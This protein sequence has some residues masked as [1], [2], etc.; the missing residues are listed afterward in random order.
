MCSSDLGVVRTESIVSI[1]P[2][3]Q[4]AQYQFLYRNPASIAD[5]A[6]RAQLDLLAKNSVALVSVVTTYNPI[7]DVDGRVIK[8]VKF[9]SDITANKLRN[10][11]FQGKVE[12]IGRSVAVT[13]Y[14]L[15]GNLLSA[16]DIFLNLMQYSAAEVQGKHHMVFC[17]GDHVKTDAYTE[18]WQRLNAGEIGRAHV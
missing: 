12:A 4:K 10:V 9:A 2:G 13:E 5:P 16:N 18:F 17:D 15:R 1:D 7:T 8:V 6:V 11:D 3:L 14:D